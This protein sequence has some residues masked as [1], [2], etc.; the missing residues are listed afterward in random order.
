MSPEQAEGKPPSAAADIYGLG[1]IL[2]ELL[3][4]RR[5][6][7]AARPVEVLR[8]VIEEEP[9]APQL[10]NR[11]VDRDLATICL[12]CLDKNPTRRYGSALE[13]AEDLGRWR[14][15]EPILARPAGPVRRLSQWT[16]RNPALATLIVG[17]CVGIAVTLGLLAEAREEKARKSIALAILRTET[18]RQLQEI[19]A[20]P[21]R[22]FAI[23]S[24]TLAAM[25]GKEPTRLRPGEKRFTIAFAAPANPLDR[26]LGAAPLLEHVEHSMS[27]SS[28][29]AT[30]LDLRLY[31]TEAAATADLESGQVDFAQMNACAYLRSKTQATGIQPLVRIVSSG[32]GHNNRVVIFTRADTGIKTL[33]DLGGRSFLFGSADSTVTLL[34]KA[35]LVEAGVRA[36]DLS[37][38]RYVNRPEEIAGGAAVVPSSDA[39]V[40][41]KSVRRLIW[42]CWGVS[43]TQG[44][45]W[46][47]GTSYRP[48]RRGIFAR[49]SSISM[50]GRSSNRLQEC[51]AHLRFL[52]TVTSPSCARNWLRNRY[53]SKAYSPT[54]GQ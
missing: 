46:R 4:G 11:A 12:K 28:G 37:K 25:A 53:S 52:M 8:K 9:V 7:E 41:G 54:K 20:S 48:K 21:S 3:T 6:F 42:C 39:A 14:R 24:E 2:Y 44:P 27:K 45:C 10:I 31:K 17:L 47:A 50:T 40:L 30:R 51:P 32:P 15:R 13:L 5:P 29:A 26:I 16:V 18:A 23:K 49:P 36:S 33:A 1:V 22:F 34:T 19:W 35:H 38:Y 43:K